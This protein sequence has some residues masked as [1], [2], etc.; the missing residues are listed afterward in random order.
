[1]SYT[2]YHYG[3]CKIMLELIEDSDIL[4]NDTSITNIIKNECNNKPFIKNNIKSEMLFKESL[5]IHK[6]SDGRKW[7]CNYCRKWIQFVD[8][9]TVI[10]HLINHKKER[11][12]QCLYC[13]KIFKSKSD[14]KRHN[15][16]H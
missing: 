14:I 10:F 7:K 13:N 15:L 1:M 16:T 9:K 3:N 11:K 2:D 6:T 8:N 5:I 4:K 12:F